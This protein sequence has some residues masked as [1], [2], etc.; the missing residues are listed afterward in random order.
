MLI[1]LAICAMCIATVW[2]I[3]DKKIEVLNNKIEHI[4]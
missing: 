1:L 2:Y 4:K 3:Y